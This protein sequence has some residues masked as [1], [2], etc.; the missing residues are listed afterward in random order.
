MWEREKG[1]DLWTEIFRYIASFF[2]VKYNIWQPPRNC[3]DYG[4]AHQNIE[5]QNYNATIDYP[6]LCAPTQT[7]PILVEEVANSTA[8]GIGKKGYVFVTIGVVALLTLLFSGCAI[9][10]DHRY[11]G[12]P[13]A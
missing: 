3:T 13:T 9:M 4:V 8:Q 11:T 10:A 1:A 2:S 6:D 7:A 12:L 5:L